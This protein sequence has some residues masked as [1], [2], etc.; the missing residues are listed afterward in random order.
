[1]FEEVKTTSL[2]KKKKVLKSPKKS[3]YGIFFYKLDFTFK[4]LVLDL[5]K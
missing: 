3:L 1:M 5:R 2:K 4:S